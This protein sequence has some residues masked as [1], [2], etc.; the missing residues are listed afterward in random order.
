MAGE[1]LMFRISYIISASSSAPF[2]RIFSIDWTTSLCSCSGSPSSPEV[3]CFRF[4]H[5]PTL[6]TASGWFAHSRTTLLVS[7]EAGLRLFAR[8]PDSRTNRIAAS[9]SS[10]ISTSTI[11]AAGRRF[12]RLVVTRVTQDDT[13]SSG[14][15]LGAPKSNQSKSLS[16]HT[17]SK[18][19]K[20][21]L[22]FKNAIIVSRTKTRK[23]S[24]LLLLC[25]PVSLG[26]RS[27][28]GKAGSSSSGTSSCEIKSRRHWM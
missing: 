28:S 20:T 23:P 6:F 24:S 8:S 26:V 25:D 16:K 5:R 12:L 15:S 11:S 1:R 3:A 19:T 13:S 4:N 7:F 17:S 2:F 22:F 27:S 10:I 14:S 9:S 18:I 21:H